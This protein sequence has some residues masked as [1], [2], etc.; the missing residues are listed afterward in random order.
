MTSKQWKWPKQVH[1]PLG[2]VTVKQVKGLQSD[3]GNP[4]AGQAN[5]V[6]L[7]MNI[8]Q[9]VINEWVNS[10]QCRLYYHE[11]A[12]F[13]LEAAGLGEGA[14]FDHKQVEAIC[15]AISTARMIEEFNK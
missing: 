7:T 5:Y 3:T 10:A 15:D 14:M 9:E 8:D 4:L 13:A 1:T 12:H 2:L 11:L 6:Q